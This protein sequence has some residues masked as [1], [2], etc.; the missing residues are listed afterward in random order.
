MSSYEL[1][2]FNRVKNERAAELNRMALFID[3]S[4][5]DGSMNE[6][7]WQ[8][9]FN[10]WKAA[11]DFFVVSCTVVA[12]LLAQVE[13]GNTSALVREVS[14]LKA[15]VRLMEKQARSYGLDPSLLAWS[16]ES[17]LI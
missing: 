16:R 4:R 1:I 7:D 17:D 10:R 2:E 15:R 14:A 6:A 9:L 3:K 5:L 11:M 12:S 8:S 13:S